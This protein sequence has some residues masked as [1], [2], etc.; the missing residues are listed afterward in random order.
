MVKWGTMDRL[1]PNE[2]L[3]LITWKGKHARCSMGN[4]QGV[5]FT[6]KQASKGSFRYFSLSIFSIFLSSSSEG[7]VLT[8]IQNH[9]T[10]R[11]T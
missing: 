2:A 1:G 9:D 5:P 6:S 8:K 10:S 11:Q 7:C 4:M 3:P